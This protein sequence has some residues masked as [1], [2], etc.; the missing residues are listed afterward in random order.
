M[1]SFGINTQSP[2]NGVNMIAIRGVVHHLLGPLAPLQ[3]NP[4]QF[5]QLYIIDNAN[6]QAAARF[7]TL[8]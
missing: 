3:G 7:A 4:Q 2:A 5:A 6:A 8:G 1:A